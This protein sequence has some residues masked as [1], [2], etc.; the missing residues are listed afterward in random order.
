MLAQT[1]NVWR[2]VHHP[3]RHEANPV[4]IP[5]RPWEGYLVLQPGTVIWD[6][7]DGC[8]K[9][10]YNAQPSRDRPDAE[11][12]LCYATSSDGANWDK[13]EL[14][15]EEF[16][17]STANKHPSPRRGVDPLRPEGL[18]GKGCRKALQTAL[19]DAD[20]RRNPRGFFRRRRPLAAVGRQPGR[21]PPGDG[22]YLQRHARSGVG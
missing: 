7:E 17:G 9:M 2:S 12:N 10:W 13:P 3:A 16:D 22:R 18:G 11:K 1:E 6:E 5:D 8:F 19:L 15:L 4:L 20:G 14:G 21:A